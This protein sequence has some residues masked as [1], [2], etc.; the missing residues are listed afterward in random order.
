MKLTLTIKLHLTGLP[1]PT[2]IGQSQPTTPQQQPY[3]VRPVIS[4]PP[5]CH[6][7]RARPKLQ[8]C[9]TGYM[10][11]Q[12]HQQQSRQSQHFPQP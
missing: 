8:S 5:F 3:G 6:P 7:R 9:T 10:A 12:Q 2:C 11:Q 4:R 1:G